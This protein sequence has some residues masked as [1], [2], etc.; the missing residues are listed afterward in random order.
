[1]IILLKYPCQSLGRQVTN[2]D[3]LNDIILEILNTKQ[4]GT[5]FEIIRQT[6]EI[7][8]NLQTNHIICKYI[9]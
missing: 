3:D 9:F 7:N 5:L 4:F 1:M 2:N 8:I 6:E